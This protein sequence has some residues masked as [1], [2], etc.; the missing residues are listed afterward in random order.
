MSSNGD[1]RISSS[2]VITDPSLHTN[3]AKFIEEVGVKCKSELAKDRF[4]PFSQR[5]RSSVLTLAVMK[6]LCHGTCVL[7]VFSTF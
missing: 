4:V 2:D 6:A 7:I 3:Y 5:R 1:L